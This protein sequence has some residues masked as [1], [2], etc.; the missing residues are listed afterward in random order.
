MDQLTTTT[1]DQST[2]SVDPPVLLRRRSKW[3]KLTA[4][5][6]VS[7]FTGG[8][9]ATWFYRKT[10]SQLQQADPDDGNSNFGISETKDGVATDAPPSISPQLP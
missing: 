10:L 6:A 3:L 5:A 7:A 4:V 1:V 8:L 2:T 9:A